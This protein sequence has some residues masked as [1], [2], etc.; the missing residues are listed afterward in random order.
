M[1][2]QTL[3]SFLSIIPDPRVQDERL[4]H[5]LIDILVITVVATMSGCESWSEVEDYAHAH[6]EWLSG[7]LELPH[8]IPSQDTLARVVSLIEFQAFAAVFWQWVDQ[9]KKIKGTEVNREIISIDGKFVNGALTEAYHPRSALLMVSAFATRAG[10]C[11]GFEKSDLKGEEKRASERLIESLYLKGAIVTL[12]ANGATT[13]ITGRI[14]RKG[15]DW[16]IGLKANQK[17][18]YRLCEQCF[19]N[20]VVSQSYTTEEKS[21]GRIEKRVYSQ[22]LLAQCKMAGMEKCWSRQQAK[23]QNLKCFIRV[24]S[25]RTDH[26]EHGELRTKKEVR[27]FMSSLQ[28]SIKEAAEAIRSHWGIENKLHWQLDVSFNEDHCRARI[29]NSAANLAALRRM[30]LNMLKEEKSFKGGIKRKMKKCGW[31]TSYLETVLMAQPAPC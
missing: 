1:G 10:I 7:F 22:L 30:I 4:K 5:K 15:A 12:D 19:Q 17:T 2:E 13:Q 26:E 23:W 27:Y 9:W 29:K 31:D 14:H 3:I 8:G 20:E 21:H 25:E 28:T 18:L 6:Q 24:E 16:L 11:L